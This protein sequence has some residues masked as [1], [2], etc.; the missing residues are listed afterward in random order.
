CLL[1]AAVTGR[2]V[3]ADV[4]AAAWWQASAPAIA[5]YRSLIA[6]A[7]SSA[8]AAA[9]PSTTG[10][11]LSQRGGAATRGLLAEFWR[12]TPHGYTMADEARAFPRFLAAKEPALAGR[13]AAATQDLAV[14]SAQ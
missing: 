14:L 7:R 4:A 6:D 11:L 2:G 10:L 9:A 12:E 8:V 13:T 1:G 5:L 3:R